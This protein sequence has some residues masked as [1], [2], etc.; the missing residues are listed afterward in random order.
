MK[1]LMSRKNLKFVR[2]D[3]CEKYEKI[4]E[5]KFGNDS[6]LDGLGAVADSLGLLEL[7]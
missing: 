6:K 2:G 7:L 1:L 5:Q 4:F 3:Q